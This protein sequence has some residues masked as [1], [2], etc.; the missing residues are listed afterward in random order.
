MYALGRGDLGQLGIGD[1]S[2]HPTPTSL[3]TLVGKDIVHIAASD[4]HTAFL[5]GEVR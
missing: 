1:Y 3:S 2:D 5:T 4:Y